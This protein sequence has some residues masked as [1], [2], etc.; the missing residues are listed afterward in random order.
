MQKK[1]Q[2]NLVIAQAQKTLTNPPFSTQG[3]G[4]ASSSSSPSSTL[5]SALNT[6]ATDEKRK[7]RGSA[8]F[9]VAIGWF[10]PTKMRLRSSRSP[11]VVF[12]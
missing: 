7:R 6:T 5:S 4:L 9:M 3:S 12:S 8:L 10:F 2:K 1:T 11:N